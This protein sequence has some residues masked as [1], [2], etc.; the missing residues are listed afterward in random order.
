MNGEYIRALPTEEFTARCLPFGEE[1]YGERLDRDVFAGA[2]AIAQERATTLAGAAEAAWFL[3]VPEEEFA[4]VPE[5]LERLRATERVGEIL[6]AV[7]DHLET[8][9]WTV[10]GV[11][12]RPVLEKLDIKPRKGLP[13]VYAAIEGTHAGLPLFDS[14]VLLG[15]KR[16]VGRVRAA[17]RLLS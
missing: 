15:R 9:E 6:A 4:I 12:L 1:C 8:C 2:M 16:A 11:D 13:A 3:F 10:E 5:S 7:A 14:I 17:I